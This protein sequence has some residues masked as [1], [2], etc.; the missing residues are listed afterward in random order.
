MLPVFAAPVTAEEYSDVA[1]DAW[2]YDC[3]DYVTDNGIIDSIDS[4]RFD[5]EGKMTRGVLV[6]AIGRCEGIDINNVGESRFKDIPESDITAP[7]AAW[8]GNNG[9]V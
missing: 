2:Y 8:A 9:I 6:T 3:V 1:A 5:P 7:Y 4:S